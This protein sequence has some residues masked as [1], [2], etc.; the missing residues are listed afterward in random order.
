M[1]RNETEEYVLGNST[2]EQERLKC[3]R[4]SFN[5]G[6]SSSFYQ[7]DLNLECG[8]WILAVEWVT[9]RTCGQARGAVGPRDRN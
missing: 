6:L 3:K 4:S 8:C 1:S 5:N 2:H 9:F 7:P